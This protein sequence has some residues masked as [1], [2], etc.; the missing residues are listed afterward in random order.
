MTA[1]GQR[2]AGPTS[3]APVVGLGLVAAAVGVGLLIP[4]HERAVIGLETVL[5]FVLTII[6][7]VRRRAALFRTAP[8]QIG[9]ESGPTRL[10]GGGAPAGRPGQHTLIG[11]ADGYA[12]LMAHLGGP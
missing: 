3:I 5:A 6:G 7:P 1:R 9:A 8:F 2:L 12:E 11:T 10:R 4:D